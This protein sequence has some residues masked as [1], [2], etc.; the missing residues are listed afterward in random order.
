MRRRLTL[1]V[2][3]ALL[4]PGAAGG[5]DLVI[6]TWNIA[7]LTTKP[8]GHPALP[9]HH[10]PRREEDFAAL[11]GYAEALAADVVAVQE[12]DGPLALARVFDQRA[13]AFHLTSEAD[14]QRPGFAI[15]RTLRFRANPDLVALDLAPEARNSLRRGADITVETAAGPLRLLSVHLKA[16]CARDRLTEPQR[17]DCVQL[18]RQVPVLAGWIR[19]RESE[20]IAYAILGDFN[21]ELGP[22]DDMWRALSEAGTITHANRGRASPCWGGTAFVDHIVL[23]GPARRWLVPSSLRVLVYRETDREA[24]ERLSDHCPVRVTLRPGG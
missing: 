5:S 20:G 9:H 21:R 8:P 15:R 16:G 10:L 13:Y 11:R 19:A 2:L 22:R 4:L 18:A 23:G 1:I 6:A 17:F 24:R 7:W 12:I 14:I 3:F